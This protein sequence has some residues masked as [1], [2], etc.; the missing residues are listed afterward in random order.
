MNSTLFASTYLALCLALVGCNGT[1]DTDTST[2]SC[3]QAPGGGGAGQAGYSCD[4]SCSSYL[5]MAYATASS[6]QKLDLYVPA[7]ASASS[8]VPLVVFIHGG[9]FFGG[10]KA[11]SSS[12][13]QLKLLSQGYAIAS[14]N[15]RLSPEARFPAQIQDAKAAIR[16]LRANASR[17]HLNPNKFASWGAS[18]G[19]NLAA[20]LGTAGDK[21][22]WDDP[23]LGNPGVSSAV[24]ATVDWFGPTKFLVMDE[25]ASAQG[26]STSGG[27]SAPGAAGICMTDTHSTTC[28]AESR[29][30]GVKIT[31]A[32]EAAEA[33]NPISYVT[34]DDPPF[35]I[36]HGTQ[37]CMVPFGQSQLLY[38]A[39]V[40]AVGAERVTLTPMQGMCHGGSAFESSSNLSAVVAFLDKYLK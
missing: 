32:P 14:I 16:W 3:T 12:S 17:Y 9:G 30:I 22:D 25:Q 26:C 35:F 13:A 2:E 40:V 28:S 39:L 29:L 6:A 19:G 8:P 1:S 15:Y 34:V 38:E 20:L 11:L 37:D 7:S 18:A 5:D 33:A 27:S 36:Q 24:Q 23:A 31:S 4:S 21:A 10:D